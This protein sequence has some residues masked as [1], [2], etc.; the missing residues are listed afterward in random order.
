[1]QLFFYGSRL[2]G[3]SFPHAHS[4]DLFP[5]AMDAKHVA[6]MLSSIAGS[7]E[8]DLSINLPQEMH[9]SPMQL[10]WLRKT[11]WSCV[12]PGGTGSLD[13]DIWQ[14][15]RGFVF[16]TR[17]H[18]SCCNQLSFVG[19]QCKNASKCSTRELISVEAARVSTQVRWRGGGCS[20]FFL[21][22]SKS[23]VTSWVSGG[24]G[25]SAT[26]TTN[27]GRRHDDSYKPLSL[28]AR[29]VWLKTRQRRFFY[30]WNK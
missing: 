13:R 8:E 7:T 11:R 5:K 30:A 4:R 1:M 22:S 18:L 10:C 6:I 19:Q 17:K 27:D 26:T 20:T 28:A 21:R 3:V 9:T 29:C 14:N 12:C 25:S 15:C 16:F 24:G 2:P 23:A